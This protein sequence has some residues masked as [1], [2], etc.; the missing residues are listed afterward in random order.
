MDI[1]DDLMCDNLNEATLFDQQASYDFVGELCSFD[2][3][4]FEKV[5]YD[6][7]D[8]IEPNVQYDTPVKLMT[9]NPMQLSVALQNPAKLSFN[10][11]CPTKKK[12]PTKKSSTR[13][14]STKQIS[15]TDPTQISITDPTQISLADW[16][17]TQLSIADPTPLSPAEKNKL[18]Y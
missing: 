6:M 13:K 16:N 11:K 9:P 18:N 1:F 12:S 10:K 15:I 3:S 14:G 7:P 8:N 5:M 2:F 17:Q 4:L